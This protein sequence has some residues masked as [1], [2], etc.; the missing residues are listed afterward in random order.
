MTIQVCEYALITSDTSQKSGLDLGIVS[1]QTFS[2]L[3]SLHQQW[4]GS[5]QIVSRQGKRFLRLG[6]YVGYLESPTGEA[7]EILPKTR[8]GED[9]DPIRQRRVLRRMLQAA[10]GITPREGETASLYRSKLPLHEWIYSEFL[11]H[12]L[13]LVRRGLRSDYHLTEDDDSAFIRGQLDINRQIRQAPG[14][15]ARFHVRYAEFTPQRIENRILR[16]VLEIVL[17]STKENQ[18]WRTAT[19][20]KHQ[21][22]DI[23]PISDALSQLSRWSDGK[24][25]LAY[26]AI[27]PWCQ[28]ILEKHN[29]DFQKGGH[30]GIT[31]LFPM[32]KLFESWVGY[33]LKRALATG[34]A[35]TAQAR[36]HHLLSHALDESALPEAWFALKP[37]FVVQNSDESY[38]L[39][40]KW[41]LLDSLQGNRAKKYGISQ[42]DLYQMFAY[43]QKYLQG[44]GDMMLIYPAHPL[45]SAPLPLFEFDKRLRLWCVPFDLETG[46]L[47]GGTWQEAISV[48]TTQQRS[49]YGV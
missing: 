20:L 37:D 33:S 4:E 31:L 3:E 38:V 39:D 44:R 26:R 6:S 35:F 48:F 43:G 28:L 25:L 36:R 41:K 30:Q 22:A 11:R 47:V 12:L 1:K 49:V 2:W 32:E 17:S 27:K 7:I 34:Y 18:T 5:A 40:A 13:E 46:A 16:T 24:Y 23:E 9:E 21:M 29:P 45:F 19:T 8:L 10:A 14:K 15:G 42:A